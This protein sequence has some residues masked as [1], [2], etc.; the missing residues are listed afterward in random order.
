MVKVLVRFA[1]VSLVLALLLGGD[2]RIL[3]LSES[4]EGGLAELHLTVLLLEPAS[5]VEQGR[6]VNV[7]VELENSGTAAADQFNVE[8]FVRRLPTGREIPSWRSFDLVELR[9][10]SP[11]EQEIQVKGV[12]DTSDPELIPAP[13]VYEIRVV[14]DSNDQIPELD[15]TNNELSTTLSVRPSQLG[16]PDLRPSALLFEPPSPVDQGAVETVLI[17]ATVV[18]SGDRDA[19]PFLVSFTHCR[20]TEAQISCPREFVEFAQDRAFA[21]GGLPKGA[22][23]EASATLDAAELEPGTYLIK[24]VVDPPTPDQ[25]AGQIEEQD[26]ANNELI[27]VLSLQGPELYPTALSFSPALPR[28]GDTVEVTATVRNS[29]K[30]TARNFQVTFLVNG[31]Q[32]DLKT[33][34]LAEGQQASIVGVLK[35][36][37][38]NLDVGIHLIRVIVDPFNVIAER[39]ETNNEIRTSLTL[40]TPLPRLAELHPKGIWLTPSSPIE[41]GARRSLAVFAE[42][43][44]TGEIVAHNFQVAFFYRRIGSVRSIP[45]PCTTNCLVAELSPGSR[46]TAKGELDL[47]VLAPGNYEVGVVVDPPEAQRPHGRVEELDEANNEMRTSFTLLAARRPDL[48]L[49]P[50]TVRIEPSLQVQRGTSLIIRLE[51]LNIGEQASEAFLVEFSLRRIDEHLFSVFAR[52]EVEGL[53]VG[54]RAMM[55]VSLDT[56]P[57]RP[58]FY[59]LRIVADPENRIEE[60]DE[61][62]NIF[63]TGVGPEAAPL[64]VRGPD[65]TPLSLSFR[66]PSIPALAPAVTRGEEVELIVEITNIGIEAAGA[67]EVEFCRQRLGEQRCVPF[68]E[69]VQFPGLGAGVVVQATTVLDTEILEPGSYVIQVVVDPVEPGLPFGQVEEENELNNLA[70]LPLEVLPQPD[71]ELKRITFDPP[72]PVPRDTLV[73]IFAEVLNVG[74]GPAR[75]PF[76]VEFALRPEGEAE[77]VPFASVEI[78]GL[79]PEGQAVVKAQ[80]KLTE[81]AIQGQLCVTVDPEKVIPES[82]EGN[83]RLIIPLM[84]EVAEDGRA[85]LTVLRLSLEPQEARV[86]ERV[87]VEAEVANSGRGEAGPFR[88]VFFY[89]R[90][91]EEK[92]VNFA[93]FNLEGL[94]PGAKRLLTAWLDTSLTWRGRFE[95]IVVVDINDTVEESN[96]ENNRLTKQL[97]VS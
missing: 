33:L 75:K 64:F 36:R 19:G 83:N 78:P 54:A 80:L 67:F 11:E 58:G 29:G 68:S 81:A 92:R 8:F 17:R 59:E 74:Q 61:L 24:V 53:D 41:L 12:L 26:E 2:G 76:T 43:R 77:C 86:G 91:G 50:L 49:D 97:E 6:L 57:L 69:P 45:L 22:A 63:T 1:L 66:D 82:D 46:I 20:I 60:L 7:F 27:A 62:N 9:G 85:D 31:A 30:G 32:F 34:T 13:D 25:P 42:V 47:S 56:S 37:E 16:K 87:R 51:V 4:G 72:L 44:N 84:E 35:T 65:L 70:A 14:V 89:R 28:A 39:D 3:G 5:P 10:L 71:L 95:I 40:Q 79:A 90:L 73:T 23:K 52:E 88:V 38:L 15:E 55:E 21:V 94:A 96:E 48:F 93:Q 18:N